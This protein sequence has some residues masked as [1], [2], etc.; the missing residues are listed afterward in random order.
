MFESTWKAI[1]IQCAHPENDKTS[2]FHGS[3]PKSRESP[4]FCCSVGTTRL[5]GTLR[6]SLQH[7]RLRAESLHENALP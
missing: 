7:I 4:G 5:V 6:W 3:I 2:E 1:R